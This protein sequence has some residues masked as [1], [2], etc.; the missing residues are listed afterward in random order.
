ML[1]TGETNVVVRDSKGINV[2]LAL[3]RTSVTRDCEA[4]FKQFLS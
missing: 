1:D 2:Q 3:A 4:E